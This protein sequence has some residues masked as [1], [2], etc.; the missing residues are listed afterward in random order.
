MLSAIVHMMMHLGLKEFAQIQAQGLP[1]GAQIDIA[2][3][4]AVVL[5]H[6]EGRRTLYWTGLPN[7]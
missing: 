2:L 4:G 6:V 1:M 5:E 3:G 7:C